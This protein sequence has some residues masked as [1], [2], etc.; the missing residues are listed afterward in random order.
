MHWS[1]AWHAALLNDLPHLATA[2]GFYL[3]FAAIESLYPIEANHTRAGRGRNIILTCV[4]IGAGLATTISFTQW[5]PA[6]PLLVMSGGPL[7][8]VA[9][10]LASMLLTDF[11]YYWYH[12]AQHSFGLLWPLHE[13]HHSDSELNVTT[14]MRAFWLERPLQMIFIALPTLACLRVDRLGATIASFTLTAWLL[15]A[16]ANIR[17]QLGVF[18]PLVCGPQLHR[19]H[20]SILLKHQNKNFAQFFPLFDIVFGTYYRPSR[21]EFPPTGTKTL[22]SN[23]A[24]TEALLGPFATWSGLRRPAVSSE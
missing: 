19:I 1:S 3:A 14:A 16:H 8:S 13:L 7:T 21:D 12:R 11:F 17:I 20:H 4:S 9:V 2:L 24:F 15:F 23:V 18:N 10:C 5:V 6:K 22:A